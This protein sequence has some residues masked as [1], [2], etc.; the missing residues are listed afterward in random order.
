LFKLKGHDDLFAVAPA[1]VRACPRLKFLL[2]GDGIWRQRFA[3]LAVQLGLEK[4]FAFAGLVPPEQ[5]PRY[6]GIMDVLVHLSR[7]EGLPRTLP[8]ALAA[9]KPVVAFDC[10]GARE[11]CRDGETGFLLPPGDRAGLE[12]RLLRLAQDAGLRARLGARGQALVKE[13][14]SVERMVD[15]LDDLYAR[16]LQ[17]R[18]PRPRTGSP[19]LA[20]GVAC[21]DGDADA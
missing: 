21:P 12:N 13:T 18:E 4:H 1:L 17:A 6:V 8:Q 3:A 5:V 2:V 11:V 14:F 10:D 15:Q 16:L 9:A 7:R 19:G 20:R